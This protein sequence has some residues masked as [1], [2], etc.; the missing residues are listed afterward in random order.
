MWRL[1]VLVF[2]MDHHLSQINYTFVIIKCIHLKIIS[3]FTLDAFT[4]V[5]SEAYFFILWRSK[6]LFW[7]TLL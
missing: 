3:I 7:F 5:P 4:Y 1:R 6:V 2:T